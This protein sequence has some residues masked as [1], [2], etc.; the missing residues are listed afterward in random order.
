MAE[1]T[2]VTTNNTGDD[3]C[4]GL[5][6]IKNYVPRHKKLLQRKRFELHQRKE[7]PTENNYLM[8][9]QHQW[10]VD[11]LSC[12]D[13]DDYFFTYTDQKPTPTTGEP[14]P[15]PPK[16]SISFP[17][18][19]KP[20]QTP[21]Q[22]PAPTNNPDGEQRAVQQQQSPVQQ[23]QP[24]P[25][26]K[27]DGEQPASTN[28]PPVREQPENNN[29]KSGDDNLH[30]PPPPSPSKNTRLQKE[31][32]CKRVGTGKGAVVKYVQQF[33]GVQYSSSRRANKP[34]T[35]ME[36][37]ESDSNSEESDNETKE[38][39]APDER[40]DTERLSDLEKGQ[41]E[42]LGHLKDIKRL[43]EHIG[44]KPSGSNGSKSS[45]KAKKRTASTGTA[46]TTMEY[47]PPPL[48]RPP[49]RPKGE[50]S[51]GMRK[52][53]AKIGD[54][55]TSVSAKELMVGFNVD[56]DDLVRRKYN[57]GKDGRISKDDVIRYV[58][59][60][61]ESVYHEMMCFLH[62]RHCCKIA[63][64]EEKETKSCK[65]ITGS[66]E[67]CKHT[68]RFKT[69]N[70]EFYCT[71]HF[72]KIA[73]FKT[74]TDSSTTPLTEKQ[75]QM[76]EEN[77]DYVSDDDDSEEEEEESN[78]QQ[79]RQPKHQQQYKSMS[80]EKRRRLS[81]ILDRQKKSKKQKS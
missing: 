56:H 54:H 37:S 3:L 40:T 43:L 79:Q 5:Y 30:L 75:Q 14:P 55:M 10:N 16:N 61:D 41:K 78:D 81:T 51:T 46:S 48:H 73:K 33:R 80:K 70:N 39:E 72:N 42:L 20:Q 32:N 19:L 68:V 6:V 69:H 15:V 63:T 21:V 18:T 76:M 77:Q 35:L 59:K 4:E 23:Q 26:N 62:N 2:T 34:D 50:T 53:N 71:Y 58:H 31:L 28:N 45:K 8:D 29:K 25:T 65:H 44:I 27:P 64:E 12:V 60:Y 9:I 74:R 66:R 38:D 7:L 47:V 67:P 22:Q 52:G 1:S 11:N 13:E 49:R 17:T 24:A 57:L 36:G